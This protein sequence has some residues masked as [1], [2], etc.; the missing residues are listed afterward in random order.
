MF[1]YRYPIQGCKHVGLGH[2]HGV[3]GSGTVY[4]TWFISSPVQGIKNNLL[5]GEW[6]IVSLSQLGSPKSFGL[7]LVSLQVLFKDGY[8]H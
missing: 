6:M 4:K 1:S 5:L 8:V 7:L 2:K 3:S